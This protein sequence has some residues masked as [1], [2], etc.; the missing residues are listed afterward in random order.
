MLETRHSGREDRPQGQVLVIFALFMVVLLA[1]AALTIDYGTWLKSRRD[2]QNLADASVLAG[3]AQLPSGGTCTPKA[4][5]AR[6]AAWASLKQQL[7]LT[8]DPATLA[9]AG[10]TPAGTPYA[11]AGYRMWVDSPPSAAGAKYPG[12]L[13]SNP[14]AIFSWVERDNSSYL[15][16]IVGQG[17]KTVSAWAT[18]GI[19]RNQFAVA[20]LCPKP[21]CP[22]ADDIWLAGTGTG[23]RVVGGDVGG[24]WHLKVTSGTSPGMMLPGDGQM[25]LINYGDCASATWSCGPGVTGGIQDP[26][27][28]AVYKPALPLRSLLLDPGYPLPSW[29]DDATAV[30]NRPDFNA[31]ST[32]LAVNPTTSTVSCAAG[33][34]VLG[35][36]S[37]DT[38][39]VKK[40][41]VILDPTF[42]LAAGQKPGIFRIRDTLSTGN[43]AFVIGDGVSIFFDATA[44]PFTVGNDG[45]I[46]LN[47]GNATAG[48]WLRAAW[49]TQG[50]SPWSASGDP[51]VVAPYDPNVSGV[52]LTFYIRKKTD[53]SA[54]GIFNM[55]GGAGLQFR[56]VLYGAKDAMGIGGNG[57][58]HSAGT[59]IAWTIKYNGNSVLDQLYEGGDESR[60]ILLEPTLGQ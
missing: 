30:P 14:G 49:T 37:Y 55:S 4:Q 9:A 60:P 50:V 15:G 2:Y 10:N 39:N 42:G 51:P 43:G 7:G 20:A 18:A 11:E 8:L 34:T 5:C 13:G 56:G 44:S 29:I 53:G 32:G 33:S 31:D 26:G 36:G 40:G 57:A 24:N 23:V 28:P 27:P 58:Q 17:D 45:G 16:R 35:P 59:I 46:V 19:F 48:N 41:C 21:T 22:Q 38:I 1:S 12:A 54:T 52:G 6:Q 3:V 47:T 25:Y